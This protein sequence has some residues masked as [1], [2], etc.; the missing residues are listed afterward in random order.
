IKP[1]NH[2][3]NMQPES[4]LSHDDDAYGKNQGAVV[5]PIFQNSLFVFEDWE[6]ID[7]AFDHPADVPIYT[8]GTNPTVKLVEE[9]LAKLAK[10]EKA[11]LFASGMGAISSAI[12]YC[13]QQGSH[14]VSGQQIYGPANNFMNDYL[15][16]KCGIDITY[17]DGTPD[18]FA[19]AIRPETSL[20]YLE[21]PGS[22]KFLIQNLS[23]IAQIAKAN[24]IKTVID[25]TWAT[26]LYQQPLAMGID[27]EVHSCSKY[28]GGHSDIV[29]GVIIG[30]KQDLDAIQLREQAWL[31]AKMAPFEAWLLLRS[32][33]TLPARLRQH[34][35]SAKIIAN[36]LEAHPKV[37]Q[38]YYPGL[39]SFPD[40]ELAKKQMDGFT[41][42]LSFELISEDLG[43]IKEF[44]NRL[45]YFKLGVSWGGHE[46]LIY[47]PA[48][49]YLKEQTP[50]Q[51]NAM[52]IAPG[53]MR[54]S[55]GLEHI[56]DLLE[57]LEQALIVV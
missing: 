20:F 30:K 25:N 19:A 44:V 13:V 54:I 24:G 10:G 46:S 33:R 32:L 45:V 48:I 50:E 29:S 2:Q 18:S 21:S 35:Q 47:P 17:V 42:L 57:D 41:G 14:I 3:T 55:V 5:P 51:F 40:H 15:G 31:G 26:P 8:R 56:E 34:A 39:T 7:E 37:G 11:R 1:I 52:G 22:V 12:L 6:A 9:K 27:L 53:L 43:A 28:L 23:A 4:L 16:E 36:F 49:S 38:V